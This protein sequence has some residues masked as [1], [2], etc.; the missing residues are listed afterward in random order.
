[1]H[2][3][4]RFTVRIG[5]AMSGIA[6]AIR[7]E[8]SFR[9]HVCALAVLVMVL[10][11]LRPEAIWWALLGLS[12]FGV[13]A[14]EL[15]NTAIENLSDGLHP[16]QSAYIRVAKDCAAAAVLMCTC[17]AL[18]VGAAFVVHLIHPQSF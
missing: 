8:R 12:A 10:L 17:A 9:T 16:E 14:A 18:C 3:N 15:L 7:R 5:Y 2:K 1:M 4:Q 11:I 6:H 13:L